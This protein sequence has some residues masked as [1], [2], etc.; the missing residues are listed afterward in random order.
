MFVLEYILQYFLSLSYL[1]FLYFLQGVIGKKSS[2]IWKENLVSL[3]RAMNQ[4]K[5]FF[6]QIFLLSHLYP[7]SK[8]RKWNQNLKVFSS[9]SYSLYHKQTTKEKMERWF[10]KKEKEKSLSF[11]AQ[12]VSMLIPLRL[13]CHHHHHSFLLHTSH[14]SMFSSLHIFFFFPPSSLIWMEYIHF[15]LIF[16]D[17]LFFCLHPY[18]GHMFSTQF[19][20]VLLPLQN[21]VGLSRIWFQTWNTS[22]Y[23]F[24]VWYNYRKVWRRGQKRYKWLY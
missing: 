4:R 22:H 19:L 3:K 18:S 9:Q 15:W 23:P 1:S 7:R 21:A 6:W 17:A 11:D 5:L 16:A 10:R 8:V 12:L 2:N 24:Q 20:H 13:L 14:S